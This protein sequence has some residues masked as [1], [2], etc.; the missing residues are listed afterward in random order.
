MAANSNFRKCFGADTGLRCRAYCKKQDHLLRDESQ[1]VVY[2]SRGTLSTIQL[3]GKTIIA[4]TC[5]GRFGENAISCLTVSPARTLKT[6]LKRRSSQ[7]A[8]RLRG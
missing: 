2:V 8:L 3:S 5:H 4:A 6:G 7:A 1:A